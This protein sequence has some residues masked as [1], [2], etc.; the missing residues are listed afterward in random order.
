MTYF[1]SLSTD[2]SLPWPLPLSQPWPLSLSKPL[3]LLPQPL[4]LSNPLS[5]SKPT[6]RW[7]FS[8]LRRTSEGVVAFVEAIVGCAPH[9]RLSESCHGNNCIKGG[10]EGCIERGGAI[11]TTASKV[12]LKGVLRG[13]VP[14]EQLHQ[15]WV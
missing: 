5:L 7:L 11:G 8:W 9:P 4:S 14:L 13:G 2:L 1:Y 15:G 10:L 6:L 12:G 3:P